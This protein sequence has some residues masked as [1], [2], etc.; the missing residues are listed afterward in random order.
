MGSVVVDDADCK[1]SKKPRCWA[2]TT[3]YSQMSQSKLSKSSWVVSV[4]AQPDRP[5]V[6]WYWS[7]RKEP[8]L[9]CPVT[10]G[11]TWYEI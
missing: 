3:E 6:S 4:H 9:T 2:A 11:K 5:R 8:E 10:Y 7:H 1:R